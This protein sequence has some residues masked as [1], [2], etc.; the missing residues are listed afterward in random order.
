MRPIIFSFILVFGLSLE[1]NAFTD[2]EGHWAESS[3]Q[4]GVAENIVKGYPD[5]TFHPN[6]KVTEAEFVTMLFHYFHQPADLTGKSQ[7]WSD[8]Y[9]RKAMQMNYETQGANQIKA[10][11]VGMTRGSVAKLVSSTQG[12]NYSTDD[13]IKWMLV[14]KLSQGKENQAVEGYGKDDVLT[15]GEALQFLKN[16]ADKNISQIRTRP[17]GM[18]DT[19]NL[20]KDYQKHLAENVY[21]SQLENFSLGRQF[22]ET[23]K[24]DLEKGII[25]GK[26][27]ILKKGYV[28]ETCVTVYTKDGEYMNTSQVL[29]GEEITVLDIDPEATKAVFCME[30]VDGQGQ[31]PAVTY[32]ILPDKQILQMTQDSGAQPK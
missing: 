27:P 10:R 28:W 26:A 14:Q 11:D 18:S 21:H 2:T 31:K 3:I 22:A 1:A 12:W 4:W 29:G 32:V 6:K 23:L 5:D 20:E 25:T 24:L 9:Y 30:I 15:R 8:G 17:N 13:S 19:R 16:L 7:H